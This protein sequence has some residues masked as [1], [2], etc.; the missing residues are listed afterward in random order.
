MQLTGVLRGSS[1]QSDAFQAG[2]DETTNC[3]DAFTIEQQQLCCNI[4]AHD[5]KNQTCFVHFQALN[6]YEMYILE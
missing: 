4:N 6:N 5:V 1:V 2:V 3:L